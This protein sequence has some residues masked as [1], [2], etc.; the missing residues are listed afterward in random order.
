MPHDASNTI[1][2]PL[3]SRATTAPRAA[4]RKGDADVLAAKAERLRT[5]SLSGAD[6]VLAELQATSRGL[7]DS[8][9]AELLLACGP[10][11]VAR[12]RPPSWYV[13]LLSAF[14]NPFN[15]VLVG[16]AAIDLWSSPDELAGPIII[17][18]MIAISVGIRFAQEFRSGR[19]AEQLRALVR[20]TATVLRR[21]DNAP[22]KPA[23]RREIAM[24]ELVPGDVVA[25]AAG[26]MVPADVRLLTAKDLFVNQAVLT[27]ES[28]PVEKSATEGLLSPAAEGARSARPDVQGLPNIA[29]MGT[30]VVSG[31]ATAVVLQTGARTWFG[32]IAGSLLGPR[33]LTSFDVGVSNVT[34]L[35]IRFIAVMAPVVLLLNGFTKHDWQEAALFAISVAV[36]L[37]PEMLALIVSANLARG[38]L[39]MANKKVVVKRLN[40]IQNFGAMD[41]LCTDKTGTLT[42]DRI[43]LEQHVDVVG[44]ESRE[45]LRLAY[46][47]SSHQTGLRNLLDR[48]VLEH[49]QMRSHAAELRALEKVDEIPFDFMRRRMSVVVATEEGKR[50]LI[51]KGAIDEVLAVCDKVEIAG[52]VGPVTDLIRKHVARVTRV[53]NE[54]GMRVIAVAYRED[55]ADKNV[56]SVDDERGLTLAGYIGFL[57]PPRDSA[58]PALEA[59]ARHGVEVKVLTGDN[60]IV[61]SKVCRDVGLTVKGVLRGADLDELDDSALREASAHAT[62]FAK[63]NPLQ[64]SRVVRVL[65]ASGH[66][67]GFLGDGIND[68]PALR[69]A[70]IGISVDTAVDIAKESADIILLEKSLMVLEEGVLEGRTTFGNMM[71]YLKM[72]A[73]SNFGNVFSVLVASV[74][75]PFLPMLA[76]HLLIQNLLYDV[77]QLS[78]PWDR[79]DEDF[80]RTP[81]RWDAPNLRRFMLFIGPISSL[82]DIVTFVV[83]WFVFGARSPAQQALFQSGWFIEGLLSQTLIVHMIRTQKIPFIQSRAAPPVIALT[84][85]VM[86]VGIAIPFTPIGAAVGL[87]P[88]PLS[89]FPWLVAILLSYCTLTQLVKT[90]YVRRFGSWL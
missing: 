45:V 88:L 90:W 21:R 55:P 46:L 10:N 84:A 8:T 25:L 66:T 56:Y 60:E 72:T 51:C 7:T 54:D 13:Q 18:V 48:A 52:E 82:F 32:S 85:T 73:S 24:R 23:K 64:K 29:L 33:P 4:A 5:A 70:D 50:L 19:A 79:M 12:E 61:A 20:T 47:N 31:T 77:S 27:G 38:A 74:F 30:N 35:L 65:K 44:Q 59:L 3:A 28:M 1:D 87:R 43:V 37:V 53:M 62:I 80:L 34:W 78:I 36:G 86:T 58:Q 49:A 6:A 67:V 63:L 40:A 17:G 69:D 9:A 81:R 68:A 71:K 11:E 2:A 89:Y 16:L 41:V 57:D 14:K 75:L 42:Q 15:A 22:D 39:A 26:D 76:I 83:L